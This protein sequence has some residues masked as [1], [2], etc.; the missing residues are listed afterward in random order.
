MDW[1]QQPWDCPG[2]YP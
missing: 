2:W 1:K